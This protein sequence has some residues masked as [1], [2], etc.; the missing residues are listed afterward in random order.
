MKIFRSSRNLDLEE[1]YGALY[2]GTVST[3]QDTRAKTVGPL[4]FIQILATDGPRDGRTE[5]N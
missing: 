2:E 5:Q 4:F 1:N 3:R